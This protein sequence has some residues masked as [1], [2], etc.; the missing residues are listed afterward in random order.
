MDLTLPATLSTRRR[1]LLQS[2][3]ERLDEAFGADLLGLVLSGSAAHGF[4]HALSDLDLLVVVNP[5]RAVGG[6]IEWLQS[7]DLEPIPISLEHLEQV[8]HYG[9]E[10]WAY[11][12]SYAWAPVLLDRTD[13]RIAHAIQRQTR[14]TPAETTTMLVG[15]GVLGCWLNLCYRAL[16]SARAGRPVEAGLDAAEAIAPFLDAVFALNGQVRP[17]NSYLPPMLDRHPVSEWTRD[18]LLQVL[19]RQRHGEVAAIREGLATVYASAR[20]FDAAHGGRALQEVF[21]E[22]SAPQYRLVLGVPAAPED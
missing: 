9:T 15:H 7:P 4:E 20:R 6:R 3:A 22:W 18:E 2:A 17:Y 14:L 19:D 5:D 13:G 21:E 8:A 11:R 10:A 1:S 16:K 12:W